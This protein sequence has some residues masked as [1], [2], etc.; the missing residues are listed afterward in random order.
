MGEKYDDLGYIGQFRSYEGQA[1]KPEGIKFETGYGASEEDL[2]RGY[3]RPAIRDLPEYD[4]TNYLSRATVAKGEGFDYPSLSMKG[5]PEKLKDK[6][7]FQE[8]GRESKGFLTRPYSA[9]ER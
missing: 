8:E 7:E 3:C 9:T 1:P 6:W 2:Q 5:T 4:R